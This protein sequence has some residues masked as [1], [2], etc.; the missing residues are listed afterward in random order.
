VQE[1]GISSYPSFEFTKPTDI[2]IN[3][4]SRLVE[5]KTLPVFVSEGGWTS[6]SITT[7]D[8]TITSSADNQTDY[9]N[10]HAHLLDEVKATAVF[11]LLFTDLDVASLPVDV[12]DNINYFSSLGLVDISMQPKD[13]LTAWDD[14]FK[15]RVHI[16]H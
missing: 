14:L 10:H 4:Y 3:Y 7:T 16:T 13:A 5:G 8:Y 12:P 9:I 11:Q 15:N 1:L 6:A 2:P